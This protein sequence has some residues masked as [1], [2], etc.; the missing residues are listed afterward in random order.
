MRSL[1]FHTSGQAEALTRLA[2]ETLQT[3][4]AALR[5]QN[6]ELHRQLLAVYDRTAHMQHAQ[7]E[8]S[9]RQVDRA[10]AQVLPNQPAAVVEVPQA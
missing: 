5:A 2:L 8:L 3:E 10:T 7:A 4:N 1:L 6:A 9:L